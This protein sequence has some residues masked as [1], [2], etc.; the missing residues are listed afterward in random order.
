[1]PT[2]FT[3]KLYDGEDV[4]FEEFVLKCSTAFGTPEDRAE[5]QRNLKVNPSYYRWVET[6]EKRLDAISNISENDLI[7]QA[8]KRCEEDNAREYD[9]AVRQN[10]TR[11]RYLD[12]LDK[13]RFWTPPTSEHV[14]LK[15]FMVEQLTESMI[16]DCK[17]HIDLD[18]LKAKQDS[19]PVD[20]EAYLQ[21][22]TRAAQHMLVNATESLEKAEKSLTVNTDWITE[23]KK[24]LKG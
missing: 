6:A 22:E 5:S 16:H 4:S 15:F 13:V 23:L 24:S 3:A 1:M 20:V 21:N 14:N 8:H 17:D 12:M 11:E 2:G 10:Q 19:I 7:A 18:E 9:H